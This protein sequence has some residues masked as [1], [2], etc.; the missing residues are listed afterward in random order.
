MFGL[1]NK[2]EKVDLLVF[3]VINFTQANFCLWGIIIVYLHA[4]LKHF[5]PQVTIKAVFGLSWLQYIGLFSAAWVIPSILSILGL[6]NALR[7]GGFVYALNCVLLYYLQYWPLIVLNITLLGFCY[8]FIQ[9][10]TVLYFNEVHLSVSPK[11]YSIANSCMMVGGLLWGFLLTYYIN[12]DNEK[13]EEVYT[14]GNYTENYFSYSVAKNL[15]GIM[16]IQAVY[17]FVAVYIA[18]LFIDDPAKYEN[19]LGELWKWMMG[20]ENQLKSKIQ[21]M[22]VEVNTSMS[23]SMISNVSIH[24]KNSLKSCEEELIENP[25]EK[26]KKPVKVQ[27]IQTQ[28]RNE[29]K[30]IRFWLIMY[31]GVFRQS[32]VC[33]F[34]DNIKI[35]G[36]IIVNNDQ[37]LTQ[38]YSAS[39]ILA[40]LGQGMAAHFVDKIGLMNCYIL[41]ISINLLN[42]IFGMTIM[43]H[44]PVIYSFTVIIC[45]IQSVMNNQFGLFTFFSLYETDLAFQ[46]NKI[47]DSHILISNMLLVMMNYIFYTPG[48]FIYVFGAYFLLD[49]SA[50]LL[51]IFYLKPM[52]KEAINDKT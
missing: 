8:R 19:N 14:M 6:K 11:C 46:L 10:L 37:Y 48:V 44:S 28:V 35:F 29:L 36:D 9:I 13:P 7:F 18:T 26:Q 27:S 42:Q 21:G 45:R 22:D 43:K 41:T 33:Y 31:T 52:M 39:A 51:T 20:K 25:K 30:S 50:V 40:T 15:V 16:N 5:D 12:P 4:Y 23:N 3:C 34:L 17:S 24:C 2:K 32:F 1:E 38:L 47:F 49:L